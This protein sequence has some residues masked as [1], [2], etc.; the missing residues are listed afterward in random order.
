MDLILF[1]I[2]ILVVVAIA[3]GLVVNHLVFLVLIVA[4]L[5]FLFSRGGTV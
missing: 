5:V 4:L 2:L 1:L 3:G